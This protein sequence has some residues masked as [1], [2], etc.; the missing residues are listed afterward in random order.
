MAFLDFFWKKAK[1]LADTSVQETVFGMSG[2]LAEISYRLAEQG[3]FLRR[4]ETRQ[5]ETSLQLEELDDFLQNSGA[6][7]LLVDA[8]IALIDI[9]EDFYYFA[10]TDPFSPLFDQAKMMKNA[11]VNAAETAGLAIIDSANE[12]FD[13]RLH[14]AET[15]G[16]D[17]DIPNGYVIKTLKC[18]YI[19]K[20]EIIRRAAVVINKIEKIQETQEMDETQETERDSE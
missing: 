13:F 15:T 4:I 16:E 3:D 18:G 11:A 7:S 14:S 12:P 9:I 1:N 19:Y 6:N 10:A 2:P 20:E 8:L 5:K 17:N